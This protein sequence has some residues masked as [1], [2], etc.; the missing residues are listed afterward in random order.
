MSLVN[1]VGGGPRRFVA[2]ARADGF[3]T[4]AGHSWSRSISSSL[5]SKPA[6]LF[7]RVRQHR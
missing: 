7:L 5:K 3:G 6:R 2:T 4:Q 1:E